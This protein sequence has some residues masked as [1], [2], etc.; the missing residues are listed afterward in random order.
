[1][2]TSIKKDFQAI[3][4]LLKANENKK[5]A[6]LMPQLLKLVQ[7]KQSQKNFVTDELG[8]V[9]HVFC[10]YH[11]K[12]EP[13]AEVEFGAKKHSASGLNSMCKEGVNQWSK[14]QREAKQAREDLLMM[15]SEGKEK[16]ENLQDKLAEIET[17]R[18]RIEPRSDEIGTNEI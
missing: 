16:A 3:Y 8:N 2:T 12:W 11:K 9:T 6:T 5:V 13:I 7:A 15:V 17:N 1:M 14:Q 10:Y 4:D 18:T